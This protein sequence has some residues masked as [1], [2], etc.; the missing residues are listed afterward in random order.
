L[1]RF[2]TYTKLLYHSKGKGT[3]DP[4]TGQFLRKADI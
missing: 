2:R 3:S 4:F 1:T